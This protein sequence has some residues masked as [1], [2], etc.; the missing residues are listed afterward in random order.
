MFIKVDRKG[1]TRDGQQFCHG[2]FLVLM[3]PYSND[4]ETPED[5]KGVSGIQ[6]AGQNTMRAAV[7]YTKMGQF[8]HFMM[9]HA[10]LAGKKLILSGTYGGDGLTCDVPYAAYQAGVP[11]PQELYEA[12]SHG[13]GWNSAGSEWQAMRD[14]G[15]ELYKAKKE[16]ERH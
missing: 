15:K 7:V 3:S 5:W 6:K 12:W 13:G 11:V 2:Y 16:R 14:F 10:Q 4:P 1:Y 8:G 9:G